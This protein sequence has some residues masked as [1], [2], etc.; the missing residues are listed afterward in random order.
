MHNL[1]IMKKFNLLIIGILTI[2]FCFGQSKMS[3]IIEVIPVSLSESLLTGESS[4]QLLTILNNGD[5]T[6]NFDISIEYFTNKEYQNY[7]LQFDGV[8]DYVD[9]GND[10]S[11]RGGPEGITIEAWIKPYAGSLG[12]GQQGTIIEKRDPTEVKG[13]WGLY[14]SDNSVAWRVYSTTN[15]PQGLI[16]TIDLEVDTWYHIAVV[17][18]D[19]TGEKKIYVNGIL[20][21]EHFIQEGLTSESVSTY[22]VFIAKNQ[23]GDFE[24]FDGIIDEVRLWNHV[25]SQEQIQHN[26]YWE[27]LANEPGLVAYWKLNE[28]SGDITYDGSF[29]NNNGTLYD[30][31]EWI[32]S[33]A[34]VLPRQWLNIEPDSGSVSPGASI[35]I[36]VNIDALGLQGGD[37]IANIIILNNDPQNPAVIVQVYLTVTSAPDINVSADTLD[38]GDVFLG[39]AYP[40]PLVISNLGFEPLQVTN[41]SCPDPEFFID[42]TNFVLN[43]GESHEVTVT[44]TPINEGFTESE[45]TIT[46]NDP[47]Q[48]SYNITLMGEGILPPVI[49]VEPDSLSEVVYSGKTSTQ[50]LTI[51]NTGNSDLVWEITLDNA[52]FNAVTFTKEDYADWTDPENQDCITSNVC[53]TRANTQG[54]FNA[55]TESGYNYGSPDDTEWAFGYTSE[56][57]PDDYQIWV[58]A[59]YGNPPGMVNQPMSLH[60]ISDDIYFDIL[61]HSWTA[62]GNGGGFS[63]TRTGILPEWLEVSQYSGVLPA[64]D[65]IVIEVNF[66]AA[67]LDGG[68]YDG[69]IVISSNDPLNPIVNVPVHMEVIDA[70]SFFT[71]QD[72]LDFGDLFIGYGD[73]LELIIENTGSMDLLIFNVEAEPE[74]YSVY[75][76]YASIDPGEM[77]TFTVTFSP[78]TVGDYPGTLTFS[79]ND[80]LWPDYIIV[81]DGHGIEPPVISVTPYSLSVDILSGQTIIEPFSINNTG[82]SDLLFEIYVV[83]SSQNFALEFDGTDDFVSVPDNAALDI[84]DELTIEFWFFIEG[85]SGGNNFQRPVAKGNSTTTNGAFSVYVK[86]ITD[87][88]D[89]GFR[90]ISSSNVTYDIWN[91][92]LPN[93]NNGWHHVAGTYSNSEDLGCLFLD[94]NLVYTLNIP[95]NVQIRNTNDPFTVG[96]ANGERPFNG[97]IDEVRL[98]NIAR[99][100]EEIQQNMYNELSGNVYGLVGCWNFN[101]G[102]G[103]TA[104]D[105]SP[106]GN[107]GTLENGVGW[108]DITAPVSP[109]WLSVIPS[110]GIIPANSFQYIDAIFNAD[111]MNGGDYYAT[112]SITSN[113]PV[114]PIVNIP[115]HM[116]VTGAPSITTASDILEFGQVFINYTD[117]MFLEVMNVGSDELIIYN[118]IAEPEE[119]DV[120]PSMASIEPGQSQFFTVYFSPLIP[121]E[122]TGT[123]TF[124]SNDTLQ[125]EYVVNL[126]GEG[127]EPP[128]I[129][130]SPDSI[131]QVMAPGETAFQMLNMNN[132]GGS[133]LYF[134]ISPQSNHALEFDGVDDYCLIPNSTSLNIGTNKVT[135]ELWVKL[136]ELPSQISGGFAGIYDSYADSYVIYED[137]NNQELRFKITDD[138]GTA[139]RPGISEQDLSLNVWYHIACVYDGDAERAKIY[140]NGEMKDTHQNSSLDDHVKPGQVA[141][142]GSEAG[143]SRFFNGIIDECRIWSVARS[144]EEIIEFMYEELTGFEPGLVAYWQFN[145]GA[146]N[147]IFDLSPNGN[148]GTLYNGTLWKGTGSPIF[149]E[150]LTIYPD[151]GYCSPGTSIELQITFNSENLEPGE[152]FCNTIIYSND[153]ATPEVIIP[154]HLEV[155]E[156]TG[157]TNPDELNPLTVYPNPF[158]NELTIKYYLQQSSSVTLE[159]YDMHGQSIKVLNQQKL[160]KGIH[161]LNFD[162]SNL[163]PGIYFCVL[164]TNEGIQ[165]KKIIKM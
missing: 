75:P 148:D 62:G 159:I 136:F 47:E 16:G 46:S 134:S 69:N 131:Y 11:L 94:G 118:A 143:V 34:P 80:P 81:L 64:G 105:I 32:I 126:S 139:E 104:F 1:K 124:F 41:I 115:A 65:S 54:I 68:N 24:Y 27:L 73:T 128:V 117:S 93:Y 96:D 125:S 6:L 133:E 97:K 53:I 18:I 90:F 33:S 58:E 26:M 92:N 164:K 153:P 38:F 60:L 4:T 112:I 28:G 129:L 77:E 161:K 144:Q 111:N 121:E 140:L 155:T 50:M 39:A 35:D 89:I 84:Q 109:Y 2:Q 95:G 88:T 91:Q 86:D 72:T 101:E 85:E 113:D 12:T 56:L 23:Q 165:T 57:Q 31:P 29:N 127:I 63:Y 78:D 15:N 48:Y 22:P 3:P 10:T 25:R 98:W 51:N 61:F 116:Q 156:I 114:T 45:L 19:S 79:S 157:I 74:E 154:V 108:T 99:T 20:D 49:A 145:E 42:T 120:S 151:T 142:F 36:D 141:S 71:A 163:K 67:N 14:L 5:S 135:L 130:V 106:N 162:G 107:H 100:Q 152:Y 37:Y 138:N 21:T 8:N 110:I 30:G 83:D 13:D 87:P 43:P 147:T 137:K 103:F 149:P 40:L 7:A 66:N 82:G 158:N 44:F 52:G 123:L 146:G 122:H 59:V 102:D 70:P 119:F 132:S 76:S 160:Q 150:W 9:C 17:Y 55:H